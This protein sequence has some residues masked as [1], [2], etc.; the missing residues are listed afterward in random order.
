MCFDKAK[1]GSF[2]NVVAHEIQEGGKDGRCEFVNMLGPW[3]ASM[4]HCGLLLPS[5][6]FTL[7]ANYP[8]LCW[9][10]SDHLLFSRGR[11]QQH[12]SITCLVFI[13][14]AEREELEGD[15][16]DVPQTCVKC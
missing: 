6:H 7:P 5:F 2:H 10:R 1:A 3:V 14:Q 11:I 16:S 15:S 9:S 12:K 13:I 8:D 4:H